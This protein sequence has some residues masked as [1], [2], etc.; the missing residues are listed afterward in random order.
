[1]ASVSRTPRR[2]SGEVELMLL[3]L[4]NSPLCR[5][6]QCRGKKASGYG[7]E[8]RTGGSEEVHKGPE[9]E[10]ANG[11]KLSVMALKGLERDRKVTGAAQSAQ[12]KRGERLCS[13]DTL[14]TACVE[15]RY[16]CVF[17]IHVKTDF[18]HGP[19]GMVQRC[20]WTASTISSMATPSAVGA[21]VELSCSAAQ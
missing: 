13:N 17:C 7:A 14:L 3:D 12:R 15:A 16:C 9:A 6:E 21:P 11:K 1:M 19:Q 8:P 20:A 5:V 10:G 18:S 2:L 4:R